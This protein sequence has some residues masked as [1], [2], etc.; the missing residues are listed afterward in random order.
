MI[1]YIN[2]KNEW[3]LFFWNFILQNTF[4]LSTEGVNLLYAPKTSFPYVFCNYKGQKKI[5]SNFFIKMIL[6]FSYEKR[7]FSIKNTKIWKGA[8]EKKGAERS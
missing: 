3:A 6:K 7:I 2:N 5:H 4:H 1:C 8:K